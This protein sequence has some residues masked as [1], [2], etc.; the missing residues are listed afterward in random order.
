[1]ETFSALLALCADNSR[2]FGVFFDLRLNKRLSKQPRRRWLRRHRAHYDV[3]VMKSCNRGRTH[4]ASL[5]RVPWKWPSNI[6]KHIFYKK[7][8]HISSSSSSVQLLIVSTNITWLRVPSIF[9]CLGL[10]TII[11]LSIAYSQT[12][13]TGMCDLLVLMFFIGNSI[14]WVRINYQGVSKWVATNPLS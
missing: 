4:A 9:P 5:K 3:P 14:S 13:I 7:C 8:V 10:V 12:K 6:A 2:S 11:I 1:M